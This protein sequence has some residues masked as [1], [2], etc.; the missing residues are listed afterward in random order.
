MTSDDLQ[1]GL[2]EVGSRFDFGEYEIEAY[3]TILEHGRLTASEIAERTDIPQPRVYDTV[4]SLSE[5]GL[6]EI[7]ESRPMEVLA[8]DPEEAF[9]NVQS[10]LSTLVEGLSTRYTTP[11]RD[12]E[13]VS[14]IKSRQTILRYIEDVITTAEYE[15]VLSLTPELLARYEE[16]LIERRDAGV[17][18]ELLLSPAVDVPDPEEY[19]YG[20]V[21]TA[22]R[23]RRGITTPVVAVADG[24]YSVYTAH[25]ALHSD[26]NRYGV[27][28]NRSE[29]GFLV[30][31]F[32]NTVVWTSA[33]T[34][35]ERR[36][37]R[38]F[39]R[40]YA[41]IRRCVQDLSAGED[42]F[43]AAV[44]GRDIE[45]GERRSVEGRVVDVSVGTNRETAAITVETDAGLVDVG[46]QVAALE[47]VEAYEITIGRDGIPDI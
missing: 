32:L 26:E 34:L 46:G 17:T 24:T 3:L 22:A 20:R 41:S 18:V 28:F 45:T 36:D 23:A 35:T 2:K 31:G 4:R 39:P 33:T 12:S 21:A 19:D 27:I 16:D 14:L 10:T 5:S 6:V 25:E 44:R 37:D 47:D 29:L 9:T 13:A 40:T 8:V 42:E 30:S 7:R 15:L 1:R 38:P 11:A 43:Y